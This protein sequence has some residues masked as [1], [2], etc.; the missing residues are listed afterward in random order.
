MTTIEMRVSEL[1]ATVAL[2]L[3]KVGVEAPAQSKKKAGKKEK[4]AVKADGEPKKKRGTTGYLMFASAMR[5][6]VRAGLVE[7][8]NQSPKPTEV[9]TEVAK[10]WKALDDSER[11]VWNAKAK[12]ANSG[13]EE[14]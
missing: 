8:G 6:E 2:L 13:S 7:D 14:D 4:S 9:I 10:R 5:P 12:E 3:E 11:E 1:E